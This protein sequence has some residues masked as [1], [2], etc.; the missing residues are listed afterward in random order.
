VPH[1]DL[2]PHPDR[3]PRRGPHPRRTETQAHGGRGGFLICQASPLAGPRGFDRAKTVERVKRHVLVDSAGILVA[4]VVTPANVAHRAAFPKLLRQA[5]RVAPTIAHVWVDKG[6]TGATVADA[7]A[8]AGITVDVVC[9]PKPGRGFIVQP[10]RWVVEPTNG[11]INHCPRLD[12][13]YEHTL[14]AH[15]GFLILSQIALLLRR[16][17]RSQLFDSFSRYR[18]LRHIGHMVGPLLGN[19]ISPVTSKPNRW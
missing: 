2:D 9:G 14:D 3:D 4:A 1:R 5:K 15:E 12:R 19:T 16:L 11:W 7:A 10:R 13:H 8:K 17:D 18:G 6:Y